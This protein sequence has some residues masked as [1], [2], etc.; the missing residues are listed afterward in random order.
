MRRFH[1]A[2]QIIMVCTVSGILSGAGQP[3][4]GVVATP[5][6]TKTHSAADLDPALLD[7]AL[8][9]WPLPSDETRYGAIDGRHLHGYVVEQAAIS[10]RYRD[11]GH[12]KFWGR[13]TGT[14]ADAEDADWL[15]AKFRG[16]GLSEVRIQPVEL[17]PQWMPQSWE[18]SVTS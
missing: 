2:P 18:V 9:E 1:L 14:S 8:L 15:A 5:G 17:V 7:P 13:I 6:N 3:Q 16:I 10:R 11:Q 12:P 4:T